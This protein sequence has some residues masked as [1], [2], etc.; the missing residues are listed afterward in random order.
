MM[1]AIVDPQSYYFLNKIEM[2]GLLDVDPI[3]L[4]LTWMKNKVGE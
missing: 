3:K 1:T 4:G 2:V